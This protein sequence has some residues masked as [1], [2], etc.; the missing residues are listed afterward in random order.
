MALPWAVAFALLA[1]A[2]VDSIWFALGRL[3]GRRVLAAI[4]RLFSRWSRSPD[5]WMRRAEGI[6]RRRGL[7]SVAVIKF[8]PGLPM[9]A[10]LFA[11][12]M[13]AG[14][15]GFLFYDLSAGLVWASLAV[16]CGAIFYRRVD[17]LLAALARMGA[18]LALA[19]ALGIAGV[20]AVRWWRRRRRAGAGAS[21]DA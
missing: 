3:Y 2:I 8:I 7:K 21:P 14:Y 1:V 13:K 19:L 4:D 15:G 16:G 6:Y 11:G 18:P 9:L 17:A 20:V 10:P 5:R 12:T